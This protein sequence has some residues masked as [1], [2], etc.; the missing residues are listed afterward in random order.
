MARIL[1]F[2]ASNFK[3]VMILIIIINVFSFSNTYCQ[4]KSY[5][6]WGNNLNDTD[7]LGSINYAPLNFFTNNLI[8]G[9]FSEN[10]D[11]NLSGF[12]QGIYFVIS[13]IDQ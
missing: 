2:K 11:F 9:Y 8:R 7:K 1:K 3:N 13:E 12:K 4:D 10:G 6:V 5:F